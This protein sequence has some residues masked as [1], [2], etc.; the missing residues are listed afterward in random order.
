MILFFEI[1]KVHIQFNENKE[2]IYLYY[3]ENFITLKWKNELLTMSGLVLNMR[4]NSAQEN[5][6]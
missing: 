5:C 3:F 6:K 1:F 2:N 4:G